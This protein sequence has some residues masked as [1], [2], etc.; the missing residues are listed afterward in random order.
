MQRVQ[1]HM[2]HAASSRRA[3]EGRRRTPPACRGT[4]TTA[5][6]KSVKKREQ[7]FQKLVRFHVEAMPRHVHAH[8][9]AVIQ[10]YGQFLRL[11]TQGK[12]AL[13]QMVTQPG[14]PLIAS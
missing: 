8:N 3:E 7:D 11:R 13:C 14:K 9:F 4:H 6:T 10:L 12:L 1:V 2:S 5:T